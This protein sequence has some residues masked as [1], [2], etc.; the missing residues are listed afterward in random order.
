MY[1]W[2]QAVK[3]L[4]VKNNSLAANIY[5]EIFSI[6][7]SSSDIKALKAGFDTTIKDK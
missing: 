7:L 2:G 4:G 1:L 5:Q 6:E 3:K